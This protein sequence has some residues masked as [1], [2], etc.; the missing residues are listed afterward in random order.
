MEKLFYVGIAGNYPNG[1]F[2]SA[3]EIAQWILTT[4]GNPG[5]LDTEDPLGS[6]A[7]LMPTSSVDKYKIDSAEQA[8][9]FLLTVEE[10]RPLYPIPDDEAL[11]V[12]LEEH[13]H[14][15]DTM[16][17]M[18]EVLHARTTRVHV[19]GVWH[20]QGQSPLKPEQYDQLVAQL[21]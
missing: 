11:I 7:E 20:D 4:D 19:R 6:L 15:N 1:I 17:K 21:S 10:A 16:R 2:G 5:V 14:S 3:A 18:A 9:A 13:D 8:L 12:W